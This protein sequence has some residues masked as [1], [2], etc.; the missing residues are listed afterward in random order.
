MLTDEIKIWMFFTHDPS[1]GSKHPQLYGHL[2]RLGSLDPHMTRILFVFFLVFLDDS[3]ER[4][5]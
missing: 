1:K 5:R 4:L 3:G 2:D